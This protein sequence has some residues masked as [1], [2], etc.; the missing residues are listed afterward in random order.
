MP[1]VAR[2]SQS[3]Q[4]SAHEFMLALPPGPSRSTLGKKPLYSAA[5]PSSFRTVPTAGH[6][7][8]YLGTEPAIRGEFWI[9]DLTTSL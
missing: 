6:A 1:P 4:A 5:N 2:K 8:L 7:Q 9:R 3:N